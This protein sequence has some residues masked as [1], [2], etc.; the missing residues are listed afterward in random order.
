MASVAPGNTSVSQGHPTRKRS[1]SRSDS[2]SHPID[3]AVTF[4]SVTIKRSEVEAETRSETPTPRPIRRVK[5]EIYSR[6][7]VDQ[8][9]KRRCASIDR[10]I[11]ISGV[12]TVSRWDQSLRRFSLPTM[13]EPGGTGGAELG[14]CGDGRSVVGEKQISQ[15]MYN[16]QTNKVYYMLYRGQRGGRKSVL[17]TCL[18]RHQQAAES[19]CC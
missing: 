5:R 10:S 13:G 14:W 15:P 7:S 4:A 18:E 6:Q 2:H 11:A 9:G 8:S 1:S 17:N 12:T 19:D 3:R 16:P